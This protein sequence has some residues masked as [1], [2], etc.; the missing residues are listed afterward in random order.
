MNCV[1]MKQYIAFV[2]DRLL[3]ALQQPK[4]S[5]PVGNEANSVLP[6][7]HKYVQSVAQAIGFCPV[8]TD[9]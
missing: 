3:V 4:A 7:Q 6:R 8:H 2:A 9:C 5:C 1:L